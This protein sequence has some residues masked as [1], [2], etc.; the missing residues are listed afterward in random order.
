[1]SASRQSPSH[2]SAYILT[3]AY[4]LLVYCQLTTQD[5]AYPSDLPLH[6]EFIRAPEAS[7]AAGYSLLHAICLSLKQMTGLSGNAAVSFSGGAM[8]AALIFA[9]HYSIRQVSRWYY[10]NHPEAHPLLVD[11]LAGSVF[12]LSM[13]TLPSLFHGS[14]YLGIFSP[15]PWHNPTY[16]FGRCF[17]IGAFFQFIHILRLQPRQAAWNEYLML[18]A[19]LALSAWGKPSFFITFLP[20][21]AIILIWRSRFQLHNVNYAAKAA[22]A[23]LPALLVLGLINHKIYTSAGA[24]NHVVWLPGDGWGRY[25]P[26]IGLSVVLAMPFPLYVLFTRW[27]NYSDTLTVSGINC[28][29]SFLVFLLLA[30]SGSRASHANFAWGYMSGMFFWQIASAEDWFLSGTRPDGVRG[31]L[32]TALFW[33]QLLSGLRY[34]LALIKGASYI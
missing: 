29:I 1:M 12:I 2:I 7:E 32:G 5:R 9:I 25:T 8:L 23:F 34:F 15:N 13:V 26:S 33:I 30:E 31:W 21:S 11:L 17:S 27:R 16:I 28:L 22:L 20:A 18:A 4:G 6:L 3:V 10:A 24:T 14:Y 19:W